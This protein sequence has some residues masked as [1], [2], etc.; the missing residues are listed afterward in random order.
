M[1]EGQR[2]RQNVTKERKLALHVLAYCRGESRI[3]SVFSH[4]HGLQDSV[5]DG[6]QEHHRAVDG[7]RKRREVV[8]PIQ[9]VTNGTSESQNSRCMFAHRIFPLM[10][11]VAASMW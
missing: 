3:G 9:P 7:C 4:N 5:R 10:R 1:Y 8:S 11:S 2:D 6:G